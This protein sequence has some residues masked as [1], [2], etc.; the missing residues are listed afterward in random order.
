MS[1][2][3]P[4]LL[5]YFCTAYFSLYAQNVKTD[6]LPG[7]KARAELTPITQKDTLP[8]TK[9]KLDVAPETKL[10]KTREKQLYSFAQFGR[11]TILFIKQPL[12]WKRKEWL[13]VGALTT[14]TILLTFADQP[15]RNSTQGVQHYNSSAAVVGG[16]I[17]GEWYSIGSVAGAFALYGWVAKD[18]AAKKIAIELFQAGVYSELVTQLLK[19]TV[20]RAR[21]YM[22]LGPGTFRPFV[23]SS[24]NYN[25]FPSGHSTSAFALSTVMARHA[26]KLGLKILAYVPA[27]F[28]LFSRIYQDQHWVSDELIGAAVGY[29]VGNWVVD[30]HEARRHK[31]NVAAITK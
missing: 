21:P 7:T 27:A 14:G 5:L 29:F 2:K 19:M 13:T 20:G 24:V 4:I 23:G 6:T 1:F 26:N 3:L 18:T 10:E 25:S 11:E 30:L 22:N 12:R 16:R 31:I 17:Y 8:G 15:L 9:G 28:T